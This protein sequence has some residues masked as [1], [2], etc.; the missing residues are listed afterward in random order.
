MVWACFWFVQ[1]QIRRSELYPLDRDFELKK[2]MYSV[3]SYLEVLEDQMP[4][5]QEPGLIFMQDNA[6][7]YIVR[8]VRNQFLDIP[9]LLVDQPPFSPDL[10]PIEHIWHYLKKVVLEKYL[11]LEGIGKGE[12]AIKVLKTLQWTAGMSYLIV[13]SR[14]QQIVCHTGQPQ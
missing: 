4:K 10:N 5:C 1:G 8:A 11:E 14:R 12:E 3:R 6:P 2:H 13:Y 9:I 7:I